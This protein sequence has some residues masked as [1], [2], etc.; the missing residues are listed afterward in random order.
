MCPR[1]QGQKGSGVRTGELNYREMHE[2]GTKRKRS[3]CRRDCSRRT[4]R[5]ESKERRPRSSLHDLLGAKHVAPL[6][7]THR[8]AH[9]HEQWG[10]RP[11]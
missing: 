9:G 1:E 5:G 10:Q 2:K 11:Q 8:G 3:T 4:G 6:P 7:G